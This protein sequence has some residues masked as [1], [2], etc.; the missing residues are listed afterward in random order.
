MRFQLR[1]LQLLPAPQRP[2]YA[3]AAVEVLE[4][5]DG[6]L[7]VRHDGRIVAAQEAPP[8]PAFLRDGNGPN[9]VPPVASI[10]VNHW[11]ERWTAHLMPLTSSQEHDPD[12]EG[13]TADSRSAQ[14]NLPPE[15]A[16]ES[17]AESQ[18]QGHVAAGH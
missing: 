17:G 18:E 10:G 11:D 14:A 12:Q 9:A 8:V 15:G 1:T 4:G 16:M 6:Q 2:S 7:K 5:L 13:A 3:G